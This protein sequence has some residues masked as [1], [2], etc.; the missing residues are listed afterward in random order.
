MP[1]SAER[2]VATAVDVRRR[3]VPLSRGLLAML[4]CGLAVAGCNRP[5]VDRTPEALEHARLAR[6]DPDHG[7]PIGPVLSEIGTAAVTGEIVA[8][9]PGR[10]TISLRHTQI[11]ASDWPTMVMTFR[12]RRSLVDR[13]KV[14]Q[15]ATFQAILRDGVGEIVDLAVA[16]KE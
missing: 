7:L 9:D 1:C 8:V 10:L 6:L 14:G 11:D 16:P 3:A 13:V 5:T 4:L 2:A 15:R 12:A